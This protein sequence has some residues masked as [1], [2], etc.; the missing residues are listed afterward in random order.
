MCYIELEPCTV[1]RETPRT[2]RKVHRCSVCARAIQPGELYIDHFSLDENGPCTAKVCSDC[3]QAQDIFAA[4][5]EDEYGPSYIQ[6]PG[7]A[8]LLS[9]CIAEGDEESETRWRPMLN[10]INARRLV[11]P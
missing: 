6:P 11:T 1:W 10:A 5:H 4:A 9:D 7:F 8:T 3:R 2:A